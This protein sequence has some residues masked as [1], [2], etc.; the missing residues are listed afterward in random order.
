MEIIEEKSQQNTQRDNKYLSKIGTGVAGLDELFYDGLRLPNPKQPNVN[1]NGIVLVIYGERGTA[2]NSLAMQ[3]MRGVHHS[4]VTKGLHT[5]TERP[6]YCT[7][8]HRIEEVERVYRSQ[9]VM[10]EMDAI[11]LPNSMGTCRLCDFF[12]VPEKGKERCKKNTENKKNIE[13]CRFVEMI[14]S[15]IGVFN[16]RLES[17]HINS[18]DSSNENNYY[19][20]IKDGA[21]VIEEIVENEKIV[22][23]AECSFL[24]VATGPGYLPD[25]LMALNMVR[26]RI[27]KERKT[28]EDE[29]KESKSPNGK[30][31]VFGRSSVVIEGFSILEDSVLKQIPYNDLIDDLRKLSAVSILVFD[32]GYCDLEI[33]AD[34]VINMRIT[35]DVEFRYQYRDLQIE[36]SDLQP[37]I[38]G[39]HRYSTNHDTLVRVYP[40]MWTLLS[41]RFSK[42]NAVSRMWQSEMFH[43]K[44]LCSFGISQIQEGKININNPDENIVDAY[45]GL[46]KKWH[47]KEKR[48]YDK[49]Y[50]I[51]QINMGKSLDRVNVGDETSVLYVLFG[52]TSQDVR[53]HISELGIRQK[54]LYRIHCW[55][56][57]SAFLWP[58]VF[59]SIIQQYIKLWVQNGKEKHLHIIFDDITYVNQYPFL[60]REKMLVPAIVNVCKRM[61]GVTGYV[62]EERT[63]DIELSFICSNDMYKKNNHVKM[64][65]QMSELYPE[66]N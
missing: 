65:K 64:I 62:S 51:I 59:T 58:E 23:N 57:D 8:R 43:S 31:P 37:R 13:R 4:L 45:I 16:P 36:K 48:T 63:I 17:L 29:A 15:E 60:E 40:N 52:K 33:K 9:V 39:R 2:K 14:R 44:S 11:K 20:D 24:K 12:D 55:L 26:K 19:Q 49:K 25:A 46:R 1:M 28:L 50:S 47:R 38:R 53:K 30:A 5:N 10:E 32:E 18:P 35:E 42:E 21:I 6:L 22:D 7:L 41:N 56:V 61:V 3:I 34:I 66:Y 54:D 27:K